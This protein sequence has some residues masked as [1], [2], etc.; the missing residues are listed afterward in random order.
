LRFLLILALAT[1]FA[2]PAG[3]QD[4][5]QLRRWCFGFSTDD[6]TIQG[7]SAVVAGG[8]ESEKYTS[9]AY[10]VRG[11]VY[12]GRGILDRAIADFDQALKLQPENF[13][14]LTN[15]G[16]AY[17]QK[18]EYQHTIAD[19]SD[20]IRLDRNFSEPI[21]DRGHAFLKLG[22]LDDALADFNTAIELDAINAEAVYGRSLARR[23]KG[24]QKA[25][26][27]DL[28]AARRLRSSI[29]EDMARL[30]VGS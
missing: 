19:Y 14:V 5:D 29:V 18:G 20:A 27:A 26:D 30:G 4:Y 21:S 2:S 25:A 6:E 7:C 17:F 28:A 16:E 23:A 12:K 1:G 13:F 8:K 24:D 10:G 9:L 22:R 11:L 15:R 3:A